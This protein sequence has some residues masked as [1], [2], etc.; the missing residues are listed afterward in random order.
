MILFNKYFIFLNIINLY[1]LFV[2]LYQITK[3]I[4]III[5]ILSKLN[6]KMAG[7]AGVVVGKLEC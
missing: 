7:L 6:Y 1:Y 5:I 3:I 2:I 4:I